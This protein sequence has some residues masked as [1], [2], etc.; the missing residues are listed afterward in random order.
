MFKVCISGLYVNDNQVLVGKNTD[1]TSFTLDS[2]NLK[3][4]ANRMNT[5]SLVFQNG[6]AIESECKGKFPIT[7][8]Q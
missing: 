3:C 1:Q 2:D 6:E 8:Q 7:P 4:T 5:K